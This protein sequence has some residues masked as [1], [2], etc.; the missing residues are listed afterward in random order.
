MYVAVKTTITP[1]PNIALQI[2]KRTH[3]T[4]VSNDGVLT[5]SDPMAC[6]ELS[7]DAAICIYD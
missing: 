7:S 3:G 4:V 2:G 5:D 1:N 6:I